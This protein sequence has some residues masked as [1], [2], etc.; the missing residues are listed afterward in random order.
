MEKIP[1]DW[2]RDL[3][4]AEAADTAGMLENEILYIKG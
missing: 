3:T 4:R 1:L 2:S